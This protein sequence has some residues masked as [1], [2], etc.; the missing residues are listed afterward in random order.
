M[1]KSVWVDIQL[2]DDFKIKKYETYYRSARVQVL[3]NFE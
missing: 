1:V 3:N 2:R